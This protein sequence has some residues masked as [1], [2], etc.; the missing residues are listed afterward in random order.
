MTERPDEVDDGADAEDARILAGARAA[1][2]V[3][4]SKAVRILRGNPY[5]HELLTL[6]TSSADPDGALLAGLRFIDALTDSDD[7]TTYFTPALGTLIGASSALAEHLI[8]HPDSAL[9]LT[10]LYEPGSIT[11]ACSAVEHENVP[12][13][14][15]RHYFDALASIAV[16]DVTE[17]LD[18]RE[19]SALLSAAAGDAL[20]AGLAYARE[21]H[22]FTGD[23][24]VIAMGK[25]GGGELNYISDVDVVFVAEPESDIP[26]ATGV[27][28][29][30]I[31]VV[32]APGKE[33]ALWPVDANLRPEGKDGPLV[34][35]LASYRTYYQTWA[36]NWEY[37][38][39]LKARAIAGSRDLGAA[40]EEMVSEFVWTA[41]SRPGFVE[42]AQAMRKRVEDLLPSATKA[43]QLKLGRG[44]LRDIEFTVQ[45]LQLVHGRTDPSI[46]QRSTLAGLEALAEQGYVSRADGAALAQSYRFLR[47]L[48]HRLQL[49]RLRRT[50][51]VPDDEA[52]LRIVARSMGLLSAKELEN[53]WQRVKADV[54]ELHLK[55][56]YRPLLPATAHLDPSDVSLDDAQAANRLAAIGYRDPTKAVQHIHALTAGVTRTA[57]IQRHLLPAMLGW[58][59][60][61]LWPDKGLLAYRRISEEVGATA[62]Y[63]R[64]LRDSGVAARRLA[65]LLST[66]PWVCEQMRA[67]PES[68]TW[69][70]DP[71]GLAPRSREA[72]LAEL[73]SLL[74]RRTTATSA[75]QAGRHLR[76]RE[77]LRTAMAQV[78]G[79]MNPD[80]VRAQVSMAADIAAIAAWHAVTKE[81]DDGEA[82][83][84]WVLGRGGGEEMSYASDI[85]VIFVSEGESGTAKS[86]RFVQLLN[87]VGEEPGLPVDAKLRPEGK[88]GPICRTLDSYREYYERWAQT[89]ERQALIKARPLCGTP[90]LIEAFGELIDAVRYP[91]T[92]ISPEHINDVRR[93]KAR[94]ERERL[95]RGVQP[96]H[97][98]KLGLGGLT[99]VEW[100][101]Q[102]L[103]MM[104]AGRY[105]ALQVTGTCAA[106]EAALE[107]GLMTPDDTAALLE[108]WR[109]AAA[110]RDAQVLVTGKIT[111]TVTDVLPADTETLRAV[112]WLV[113]GEGHPNHE[114]LERYQR[115]ARRA[116][117]VIER[118]FYGMRGEPR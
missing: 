106:L 76:R 52:T 92:G 29:T 89:W 31:Q 7:P 56:F 23:F 2:C 27:A 68:I 111:T 6:V 114:I 116:R 90:S 17:R 86:R 28:H 84:V 5:A 46:R 91:L 42:G 22:G 94:V 104:Y 66:S 13:T 117:A 61:G 62:W 65:L 37:Q 107:E 93:M 34:R 30:L 58:I 108:A 99:D 35:S 26:L 74:S 10:D 87:E 41:A 50:H 44:G 19:V 53:T 110:I 15:R 88:N 75:A 113:L 20:E 63:M 98:I 45:L 49:R 72:L 36:H 51:V 1:G 83:A 48:E 105:P 100:M 82:W 97:H 78:L 32:S 81:H 40:F 54:R 59:A 95:P 14:L 73:E 12:A 79:V 109:L 102:L 60:D 67:Y 8:R 16:A 9:T 21:E 55:I 69:L 57:Q 25:T 64:T 43:R 33:P 18:V 3:D 112:T 103:Q 80:V 115:A 39:L 77:L 11:Y 70:E 47:T 24:A 101:A 38:A 85:D 4:P 118:E 71:N 96:Q